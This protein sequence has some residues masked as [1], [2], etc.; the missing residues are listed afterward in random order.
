VVDQEYYGVLQGLLTHARV[1]VAVMHLTLYSERGKA[2][3]IANAL[4]QAAKRGV[5]VTVLLESGKDS[6]ADRN[7]LTRNLLQRAGVGVFENA[8]GTFVHS[9]L[10]LVDDSVLV[11]SSNLTNS[12]LGRNHEANVLI[13]SQQ[14]SSEL[15]EYVRYVCSHPGQERSVSLDLEDGFTRV[16]TDGA[17]FGEALE[18][19][20][21]ARESVRV[22]TYMLALGRDP[23]SQVRSL[24]RAIGRAVD[25]G[26]HVEF[27]LEQ[28]DFAP[29]V[30][31]MARYAARHLGALGVRAIRKDSIERITHS[32]MII[33]D[34]R[35]VLLGSTNWQ[36][37]GRS[38]VHQ[39]NVLTADAEATGKLSEYFDEL[40][41]RAEDFEAVG[42]IVEMGRTH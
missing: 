37:S 15:W 23:D 28:S 29:H 30:N 4:V 27:L 42:E 1:R 16:M 26:V 2:R 41:A 13:C 39:V 17:F 18:L 12:S 7:M 5:E 34:G 33:V 8:P 40:F 19:I 32:K 25:R 21:S 9:K 36:N 3:V 24:C 11:G 20:D 31:A 22:V 10:L 35:R 14:A 38:C 6:V